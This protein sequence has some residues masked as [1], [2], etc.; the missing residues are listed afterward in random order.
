MVKNGDVKN[1]DIAK[2]KGI[3]LMQCASFGKGKAQRS[4]E[5]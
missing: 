1:G 5:L 4:A 2:R 3:E